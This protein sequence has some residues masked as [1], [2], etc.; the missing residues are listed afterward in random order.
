MQSRTNK[1]QTEIPEQTRISNIVNAIK[2]R[3]D[4][5][6]QKDDVENQEVAKVMVK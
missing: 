1:F 4:R 2:N 5:E 6:K 3:A